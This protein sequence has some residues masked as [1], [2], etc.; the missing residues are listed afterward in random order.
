MDLVIDLQE[1]ASQ[2]QQE[3]KEELKAHFDANQFCDF[4]EEWRVPKLFEFD[5]LVMSCTN[6]EIRKLK[7]HQINGLHG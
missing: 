1:T 7:K 5:Q 2:A 6:D 4:L 3:R